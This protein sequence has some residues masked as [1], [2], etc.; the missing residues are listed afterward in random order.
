ME[1]GVEYARAHVEKWHEAAPGLAVE[2]KQERLPGDAPA[3]VH[4]IAQKPFAQDF[5]AARRQTRAWR[6]PDDKAELGLGDEQIDVR[7]VPWNRVFERESRLEAEGPTSAVCPERFG[8]CL[9]RG[10]S[11]RRRLIGGIGCTGGGR[12]QGLR[13]QAVPLKQTTAG[14]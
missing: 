14:E 2:A 11:V 8:R 4:S 6:V 1:G 3:G 9:K 10:L 5:E 13:A 7:N 12:V